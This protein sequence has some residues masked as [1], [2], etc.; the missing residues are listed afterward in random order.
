MGC[1]VQV[2]SPKTGEYINSKTWSDINSEVLNEELADHLFAKTRSEGFK[3]WFGDVYNPQEVSSQVVTEDGEPLVVYHSSPYDFN[4]FDVNKSNELGFHFGTLKAAL[5]R[6]SPG[7]IVSFEDDISGE[8]IDIPLEDRRKDLK[9]DGFI[10][11]PYFLNIRNMVEGVDNIDFDS[12]K[13]KDQEDGDLLKYLDEATYSN[14]FKRLV[15]AF[16][17][18]GKITYDD[19]N[20]IL[21]TESSI[22][23]SGVHGPQALRKALGNP[24]GYWY[25]NSKEDEGSIS[26]VVFDPNNIKSIYNEGGFTQDENIMYQKPSTEGTIVSEKTIRDLAAKMANRIG[27]PIKF[28]S[29]RKKEYKGKIESGVAYINLAYA[30]LDTPIH[31]ILGHPIIRA[32]KGK[33]NNRQIALDTY[34]ESLIAEGK[35]AKEAK[36]D[37]EFYKRMSINGNLL[38][39]NLLKELEIGRGK[40]VLNRIKR[41]YITKEPKKDY[42][43]KF[44][45]FEYNGNVYRRRTDKYEYSKIN[46][47]DYDAGVD[48]ETKLDYDTYRKLFEEHLNFIAPKYTLEEQQEEAIVELL[49]LMAAEK[50][51]A[52]KDGKLISLLKRLLKEIKAF[53]KQL[54]NQKEVEIDK[55]P[56]NMTINDLANLLAYSNS[57]L[58]LPG[59]EVQYTTPDNNKF[60]TYQEA[61]NHISKLGKDVKDVNLDNISLNIKLSDKEL[62][63]IKKLE[64]E[65]QEKE[66]YFNSNEYKKNKAQNLQNLNNELKLLKNKKVEFKSQEPNLDNTDKNKYGFQEYDYV[67]V[68][69]IYSRPEI[70]GE[71]LWQKEFG[72]DFEGYYIHGYNTDKT[73][74]STKVLKITKEEA[75]TI[76]RKEVERY[77]LQIFEVNDRQDIYRLEDKIRN[78]EQDGDIKYQIQKLKHKIEELKI[79]DS[80]IKGFLEKN[81]EYEQSKEIIEEWKKANKIKY[82]PEEIYSRGQEFSSVVG[83]YSSFDV[84]LMM[85]NL[86]QH[87]EDNEKAGGK[88]AISAYTKPIDKQIGHLEG[89]G[90]K[91]KFKL[92]PQSEDI[93]WAA[94]TDVYSGSVWDASEKVNKDKKSELL[95]V[96][97]TKYPALGNVNTVQPNLASIVEDLAHHHNE[98]GITLTGNNF[99][100]EYDDNIPYTT[101]KIIDGINKIL[102]QKY[103]K[104]VKPDTS[105][106]ILKSEK[107]YEVRWKSNGGII[108]RTTDLNKA[109]AEMQGDYTDGQG[110]KLKAED[111][112]ELVEGNPI[113]Q[114]GIQP[115]QTNETLKESIDSVKRQ[116]T[117]I[118]ENQWAVEPYA[119]GEYAV[120]TY[121]GEFVE[122]QPTFKSL[123]EANRWIKINQPKQKEYTSQALINT[124]IA[125]LKEVAKK[126]PRSLIRSEVKRINTSSSQELYDQFGA[127]ELPFQKIPSSN[128]ILFNLKK[129]GYY[130]SIPENLLGVMSRNSI[131]SKLTRNLEDRWYFVRGELDQNN[132]INDNVARYNQFMSM[133]NINKDM[134]VYNNTEGDKA[135][136]LTVNPK[137]KEEDTIVENDEKI[138]KEKYEAIIQFFQDKFGIKKE[139]IVYTSK[140]QFKKQFPE[141]YQENMQSVYN[142]G[143]FYFFTRNLTS[144]IT[145]EELLHPFI[146][147]VKELNPQLFD[148]LLKEAKLHYPKL[149]TKIQTLYAGKTKSVRDQELVTQA[150]SRVFNNVYENEESQS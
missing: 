39:D 70:F 136:Y 61:S 16:Y 20:Q 24:D 35:T 132:N 88:F 43:Y 58:I 28:E 145:V 93:L 60:K 127:D 107:V 42:S 21:T 118:K 104:L 2:Y 81:K 137:F 91:I 1:T 7:K 55:L 138:H 135:P 89:G 54:L 82:N 29:D 84:N 34:Y 74:P 128:T 130:K 100:L 66:N 32:I 31:E 11:K 8:I 106:K 69:S 30:T 111:V 49:G 133:N 48:S 109:K 33:Y 98:L 63:E 52:V 25:K 56:D 77:P 41:D 99:R 144:D 53:M 67:R 83:A 125:K 17:Q 96:S 92:Y 75:E 112:V 140:E 5:E 46:K 64:Q 38:Y 65:K 134:F 120:Y 95:G 78:I 47:K 122:G 117:S 68:E 139:Q 146:Y 57:N 114:V 18:K 3:A 121:M 110:N 150:L 76:W 19:V 80:S 59:Y 45:Y 124:K 141:A 62:E 22:L 9:S 87:I 108:I 123:E 131:L 101:K 40:E 94:N 147:T 23:S 115:T 51:D 12:S 97:Y 15:L 105:K 103:G 72:K 37:V 4:T 86:L 149:N 36:E 113:E 116:N 6:F 27:M 148:N 126:Y 90:G 71:P 102:D 119:E 129:Q 73:K 85:Q 44:G 14:D 26:Y 13:L 143:K 50:L 79:G 142:N 10:V